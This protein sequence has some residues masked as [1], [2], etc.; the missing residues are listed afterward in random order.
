MLNADLPGSVCLQVVVNLCND[1][2]YFKEYIMRTEA[3]SC[4]QRQ[5]L[6]Q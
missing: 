2:S 4:G 5:M 3:S 6:V 1:V